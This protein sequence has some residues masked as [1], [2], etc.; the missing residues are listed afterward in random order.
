MLDALDI[1]NTR[2][3]RATVEAERAEVLNTWRT[4]AEACFKQG[5]ALQQ[6]LPE[7]KR[8]SAALA[9]AEAEGQTLLQPRAGV[10][11]L[12]EHTEL[13]NGLAPYCDL[14]PTT[15]DAYTRHNRYDEAQAGIDKSRAAGTS[16]LNGFP[17]V[18]H[19]V[20]GCRRLIEDL[21]KPVQVRH[22]TPDARLMAEITL[23][24][25][26]TSYEGGGISYNIPYAKK[27][28]LAQSIRHWQ[29]CDRL[30]GLY[31]EEGIR[32]NRE[33]FGPLTGTLVP[34]F[35]SHVV[36]ILEGLLAL[37]QG[38]KCITLG[39]GQAG[40]MAQDIA[41]LRSLRKLAH[42]YFLAAG[43]EDYQLT[44]VFH[45]WMGGFPEDEAKATA[46]ICLGAMAAK[47]AC[48]TKIIVKTPHEASG[49]P[50]LEANQAGLL[51]T[52]QMVNMVSD[53]GQMNTTEIAQEVE[54]IEAEVHAVMRR[55]LKLGQ[56]DIARGAVLAFEAGVMDVPFA[57]AAANA[58]RL[59]PVRDN[60]GAI[61]VFDRG[62]VPL[63]EDV[64][65]FHRDKIAERARAEGREASFNVVVDDVNA[66]SASKL[67][68]RPSVRPPQT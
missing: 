26:F 34:P 45:Q 24:A 63:P 42:H 59:T 16:L 48:A 53:Q 7:K 67:I 56:G 64:I 32:I 38:V 33:P 15:V 14:L 62:D 35:I 4:G 41:A 2:L 54:V 13:L 30:V 51:A 21:P 10:A 36:A 19:G 12:R 37:E 8:F 68:G 6:A 31:E 47:Y 28:P 3:D 23:A 46:V 11:L 27:V 61:R 20:D 9:R 5:T 29:Y 49:I 66:I 65:A 58:G 60:F 25:G 52:R 22:G 50:T 57:P 39:Y 40:N 44:T 18:N 17:A 1:S 55:I 43:H